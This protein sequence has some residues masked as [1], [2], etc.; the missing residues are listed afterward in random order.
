MFTA[1]N[2]AFTEFRSPRLG[3]AAFF[4][5]VG[6]FSFIDAKCI[7][8]T[9]HFFRTRQ[10]NLHKN[11][12]TQSWDYLWIKYIFLQKDRVESQ[13]DILLRVESSD[14]DKLINRSNWTGSDQIKWPCMTNWGCGMRKLGRKGCLVYLL[15]AI[16]K[17]YARSSDRVARSAD[18]TFAQRSLNNTPF[19][20][21][22]K[23]R[24]GS[25]S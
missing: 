1:P 11:L 12:W 19:T 6:C 24:A 2:A 10:L 22:S 4:Y 25:F 23:H 21:S 8:L 14:C 18:R 16:T 15:H 3:L 20:W 13:F 7:I 17:T 5:N 9:F